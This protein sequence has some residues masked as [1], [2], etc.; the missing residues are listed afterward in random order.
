MRL[1]YM[2]FAGL[3]TGTIATLLFAPEHAYGIG[4]GIII[5]GT[6]VLYVLYRGITRK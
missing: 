6:V 4:P 1:A 3:G 5:S 2:F